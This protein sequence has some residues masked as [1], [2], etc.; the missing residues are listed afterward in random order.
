[1]PPLPQGAT[2]PIRHRKNVGQLSTRQFRWLRQGYKVLMGISDNRG[3]QYH[4]GV[5]GLP[6][7][8]CQHHNPP[9]SYS[10]FLPWHRAYLYVFERAMRDQVPEAMVPWWNWTSPASRTRGIPTAFA[11]RTVGGQPNPL[12]QAP[13]PPVARI[14]GRPRRTT[15][16]PGSPGELP[17]PQLIDQILSLG[18]FRDFSEQLEDVHDGIHG[19]VGG[20]M[21][22]IA[23]AAY[24]PIFWSHHAMIDRLWAIWQVRHAAVTLPAAFLN[25]ALPPFPLTVGETLSTQALGYDYAAA[26][27]HVGGPQQ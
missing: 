2:P 14:A 12:F 9:G 11:Q 19:W 10:L 18:D 17:T 4:A 16:Q 22:I 8:F 25:Q 3:Y 27:T 20:T 21:G 24:D 15:R 26:T 23:W 7:Q 6:L 5:H 13:V 1:M